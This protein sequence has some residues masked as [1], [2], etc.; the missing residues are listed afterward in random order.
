VLLINFKQKL[1]MILIQI[2]TKNIG[3]VARN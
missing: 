3:K 1:F 2:T